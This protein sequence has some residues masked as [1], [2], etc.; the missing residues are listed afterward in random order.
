[1]KALARHACD[2]HE[3]DHGRCDFHLPQVC[4]CGKCENEEDLKCV[5]KDYHT[6]YLLTCPFHSLADRVPRESRNG[7]NVGS[8]H[9]EEGSF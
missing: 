6:K 3:W 9:S 1:M 2:E 4:S 5:G 7:Q 8:L